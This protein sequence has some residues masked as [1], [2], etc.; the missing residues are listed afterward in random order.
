MKNI[1]LLL[2]AVVT[3]TGIAVMVRA[4]LI[5]KQLKDYD[6]REFNDLF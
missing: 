1:M 4:E 3:L 5:G 6:S 2:F